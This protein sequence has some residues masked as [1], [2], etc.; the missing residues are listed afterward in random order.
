MYEYV[1]NTHKIWNHTFNRSASLL[2]FYFIYGTTLNSAT[3]NKQKPM[4]EPPTN[5]PRKTADAGA[6]ALSPRTESGDLWG[7]TSAAR[8]PSMGRYQLCMGNEQ[9]YPKKR[10][11]K[12][13]IAMDN[14]QKNLLNDFF[15]DF[16]SSQ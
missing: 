14:V 4:W 9:R 10:N 6:I 12:I 7:S 2:W 5:R 15:D 16:F 8:W 3:L 1:E 13:S 11:K